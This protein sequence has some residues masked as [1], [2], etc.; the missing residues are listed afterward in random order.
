MIKLLENNVKALLIGTV[1]KFL[2]WEIFLKTLTN[3][4]QKIPPKK[5]ILILPKLKKKK[6]KK[7]MKKKKKK[8]LFL[9][10]CLNMNFKQ[11]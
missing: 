9:K 4:C 1:F 8:T 11:F 3:K 5:V 7:K 2:I 6:K 10:W